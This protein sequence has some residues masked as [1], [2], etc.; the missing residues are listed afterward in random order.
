MAVKL[1]YL[2]I[3]LRKKKLYMFSFILEK[4]LRHLYNCELHSS[5]IVGNGLQLPHNGLGVVIN[6]NSIIGNN[7]KIHQNV[8]IGGREGSGCPVIE[9]DVLIGAGAKVLGDIR[10]GCRAKI[11]ANAV[12]LQNVPAD[13]IAVGVPAIIKYKK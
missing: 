10:V 7:V 2:A 8:T 9:D 6:P 1:F 3:L 11:G 5:M 12:V 13:S 4:L